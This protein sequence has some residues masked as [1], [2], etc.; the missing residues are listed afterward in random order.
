MIPQ[1]EEITVEQQLHPETKTA[2]ANTGKLYGCFC[3]SNF[4]ASPDGKAMAEPVWQPGLQIYMWTICEAMG[5]CN[6]TDGKHHRHHGG[7][8]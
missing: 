1:T 6:R 7:M 2:S 3:N 5:A 4:K 8:Y